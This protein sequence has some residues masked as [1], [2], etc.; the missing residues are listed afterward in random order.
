MA[1]LLKTEPAAFMSKRAARLVS[2][3]NIEDDLGRVAE[4]DWIIEA[5]VERLEVKQ[6]LYRRIDEARR[7]GTPSPPTPRRSRSAC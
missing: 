3:G 2:T 1:K 6:A 4:C 7:P 5:V